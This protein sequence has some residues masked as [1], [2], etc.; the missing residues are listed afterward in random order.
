M[1]KSSN[2]LQSKIKQN[3]NENPH[4]HKRNVC[5]SLSYQY[6]LVRIIK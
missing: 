6:D 3:N 1:E 2:I 4:G 5:I